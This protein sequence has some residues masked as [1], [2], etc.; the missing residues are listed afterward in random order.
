[1]VLSISYV[2]CGITILRSDDDEFSR[3]EHACNHAS[4]RTVWVCVCAC[5]LKNFF[6]PCLT[7]LA[8]VHTRTSRIIIVTIKIIVII[9]II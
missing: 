3:F 4:R 2:A 7:V 1:M 6:C 5:I 8:Y 9:I